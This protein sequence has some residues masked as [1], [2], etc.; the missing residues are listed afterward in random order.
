MVDEAVH[1]VARVEQEG[2]LDARTV[3]R[4]DVVDHGVAVGSGVW[5]RDE[6]GDGASGGEK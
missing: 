4:T 5:D 1:A 2:E 6:S 3:V